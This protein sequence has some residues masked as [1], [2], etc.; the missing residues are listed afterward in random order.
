MEETDLSA[1]GT[2]NSE[3]DD[4]TERRKTEE[5]LR[6]SEERYR[7]L[8]ENAND[9]IWGVDLQGR[10]TYVSPSVQRLT[11][12]TPEEAMR[13]PLYEGMTPASWEA[14]KD[15]LASIMAAAA[16]GEATETRLVEL[17]LKRKDGSTIWVEV[18]ANPTYDASGRLVGIQGI[19]RDITDRRRAEEELRTLN[20]E[21]EKKVEE[22]TRQLLD[23]QEELVRNEKLSIVGQLAGTVGHEIRNPLMVISNAV[24]FLKIVMPDADD[25]VKEYL[26]MI[27]QEVDRSLSI[28]S[29]LIDFTRTKTPMA[30]PVNLEVLVTRS[31]NKRPIPENVSVQLDLPDTLPEAN[32]DPFQLDHVLDNIITNSLQAMAKG[33]TVCI[34]AKRVACCV[35]RDTCSGMTPNTQHPTPDFIELRISDTGEGISPENQERLFHPLFTTKTEGMGL[36]LVV[37]RKLVEVNKGRIEVESSL[38]KGTTV[39]ITLPAVEKQS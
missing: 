4:T 27:K 21:L 14:T 15:E 19:S 6:R 12:Y 32:V 17:E 1:M 23:A 37:A 16:A 13:T 18:R 3:G 8:A 11:G 31:L 24:Y 34:S 7:L 25:K 35:L 33:G 29:I 10:N 28:I 2:L 22:G 5:A 26:D 20:Q 39:T 9:I 36:G 38:G 30:V